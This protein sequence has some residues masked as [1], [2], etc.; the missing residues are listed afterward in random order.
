MT[1]PS[2]STWMNVGGGTSLSSSG[3]WQLSESSHSTPLTT[4][5]TRGELCAATAVAATSNAPSERK[6]VRKLVAFVMIVRFGTFR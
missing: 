1:P 2:T 5:H 4:E 3:G 6:A